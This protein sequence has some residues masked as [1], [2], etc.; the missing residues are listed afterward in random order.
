MGEI[1]KKFSFYS[2]MLARYAFVIL[3]IAIAYP[4]IFDGARLK[5]IKFPLIGGEVQFDNPEKLP[6]D[7]II[8][9]LNEAKYIF[10]DKFMLEVR[11]S[12]F[13]TQQNNYFG[14]S[15]YKVNAPKET[16]LGDICKTSSAMNPG[17]VLTIYDNNTYFNA[18]MMQIKKENDFIYCYFRFFTSDKEI[19]F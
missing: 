16:K 14:V 1:E 15:F 4:F 13:G 10:D 17:D 2:Y 8:I 9:S 6:S 11:P 7:M 18:K 12:D 19:R 5:L 3:A